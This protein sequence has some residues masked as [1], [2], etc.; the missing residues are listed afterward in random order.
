MDSFIDLLG[1]ILSLTTEQLDELEAGYKD[2]IASIA[3]NQQLVEEIKHSFKLEG[4]T[5]EGL[6]NHKETVLAEM[7]NLID[8]MPDL[9]DRHKTLGHKILD[10]VTIIYNNVIANYNFKVIN[11]PVELCHENAKLP[12]YAHDDDAGFDFYLPESVSIEPHQ[13]IIAKTGLKM[14]IPVGYELQIRPRSGTSFKTALRIANTPGTIDSGYRDEI[15]IICWNTSDEILT[16]KAGER[17]AQGILNEIPRGKFNIVE[18]ITKV[19]GSN[20]N[21]GFGSSGK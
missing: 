16:F 14:A 3:I 2:L 21:G 9:T 5:L 17:I 6:I 15:G 12:T 4:C 20:R 8:S 13:T 11:I 7:R 1:Q 10:S 18:D 19:V